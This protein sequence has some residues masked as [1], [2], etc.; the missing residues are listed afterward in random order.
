MSTRPVVSAE[1]REV[2]GKK[3]ANL[4]RE[5]ILPAVVYG[6][7]R[8]SQNIQLDAREFDVLRRTTTRNTLVDLKIGKAKATP[9]LLQ[10]IHEHP[11]RR[12]PVHVDFLRVD[13]EAAVR[14]TEPWQRDAVKSA[15]AVSGHENTYTPPPTSAE[16]AV[17]VLSVKRCDSVPCPPT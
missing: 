7:G 2:V 10:G 16:L 12:N 14:A 8:E 17:N 11:V 1:P 13:L 3:V 15:F 5:G 4:R 9:V 6:A